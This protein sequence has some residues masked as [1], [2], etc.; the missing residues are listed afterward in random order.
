MDSA[1]T[2]WSVSRGQ[3]DGVVR[4]ERLPGVQPLEGNYSCVVER[5]NPTRLDAV[6]L[7]L[8]WPSESSLHFQCIPET[9]Y[10]KSDDIVHNLTTDC[11][12]QEKVIIS[13]GCCY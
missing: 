4:L 8:Y 5:T 3:N 6:T 11:Y 1:G 12:T 10:S 9:M 13:I 2:G 7:Y